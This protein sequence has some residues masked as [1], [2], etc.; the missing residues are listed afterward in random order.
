MLG[1]RPGAGGAGR[2]AAG[3]GG[4]P[5]R[6]ALARVEVALPR[7]D[8]SRLVPSLARARRGTT[9]C[10]GSAA[11][12]G[13]GGRGYAGAAGAG[14]L[15]GEPT[16][17][18]AR[19]WSGARAPRECW[20]W[21]EDTWATWRRR[22]GELGRWRVQ[23]PVLRAHAARAPERR[24]PARRPGRGVRPRALKRTSAIRDAH[25]LWRFV[26]ERRSF[27]TYP[28]KH[29]SAAMESQQG[30]SSLCS[31]RQPGGAAMRESVST[32][33][34]IEVTG[35]GIPAA[36]EAFGEFTVL[37]GQM[38]MANGVG[39]Q[40]GTGSSRWT[41]RGGIRSMATS[42]RTGRSSELGPEMLRKLG[43]AKARHALF[44]PNM[45][46][47]TTTMQSWSGLPHEPP[48][49]RAHHVRPV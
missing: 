10:A 7:P 39:S 29:R 49:A 46:D 13:G 43:A 1:L 19:S 27:P 36:L 22:A 41:W 3:T 32:Y 12:G 14:G 18:R 8:A 37:A 48:P 34:G 11:A 45:V 47:I 5:V 9:S 6:L 26:R 23:A 4:G 31:S 30:E 17:A 25:A 35:R 33:S 44:P 20:A 16:V 2:S 15:P 42:R 40:T 28:V 21:P 24:R 38:L